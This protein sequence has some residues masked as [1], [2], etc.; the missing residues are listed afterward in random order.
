YAFHLHLH[1]ERELVELDP[2]LFGMT[3]VAGIG[4]LHAFG[5]FEQ[6]IGKGRVFADMPQKQFPT[7]PVWIPIPVGVRNLLP[8]VVY[9]FTPVRVY[10]E[11]RLRRR[12]KRLHIA[13]MESTDRRT[14]GA[15]DL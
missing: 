12:R 14:V 10:V 1:S 4:E 9:V 3:A 6:R 13:V 5:A 2:A 15:V 11:Q 7:G 8:L